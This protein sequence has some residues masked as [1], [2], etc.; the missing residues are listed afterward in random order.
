MRLALVRPSL[1]ILFRIETAS[2]PEELECQGEILR[3]SAKIPECIDRYGQVV[4]AAVQNKG[5]ALKLAH[6]S[7]HRDRQ[8]LL[9]APR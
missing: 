3:K 9:A 4:L 1:V 2:N 7:L 6:S 5:S 8:L